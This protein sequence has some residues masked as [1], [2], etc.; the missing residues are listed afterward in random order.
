MAQV[1]YFKLRVCVF[2]L[3][4]N[5]FLTCFWISILAISEMPRSDTSGFMSN[6]WKTSTRRTM[7]ESALED[8]GAEPH[9]LLGIHHMKIQFVEISVISLF[10]L[11]E[12]ELLNCGA[13]VSNAETLS[14]CVTD[15]SPSPKWLPLLP[16]R[17]HLKLRKRK[18]WFPQSRGT[19]RRKYQQQP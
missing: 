17:C 14:L 1:L 6:F 16:R 9:L 12:Q 4:C 8:L 19:K 15:A 13:F 5:F 18:E 2:L 10:V 11:N 3:Y 7:W